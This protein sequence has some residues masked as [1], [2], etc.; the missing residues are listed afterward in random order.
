MKMR[1]T[2]ISGIICFVVGFF[3]GRSD[4]SVETQ[5]R[6]EKQDTIEGSYGVPDLIPVKSILPD[7]TELPTIPVVFWIEDKEH[8]VQKVDTPAIIENYARANY[9]SKILYDD[10][11]GKIDFS[12]KVQYNRLDSLSFKFTP[13]REVRT[14]VKE[15]VFQPFISAGYCTNG[16][17]SFG[18]G[19][20]YHRIGVEYSFQLRVTS[21][22]LQENYHSFKLK[23]LF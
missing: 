19:V 6:Y 12:G 2:L 11:Y 4:K 16:Y 14:E 1:Y 18:G 15:G 10:K 5:V 23:Y 3:I 22:K 17:F 8:I 9:Y 13:I 20:F 21:Y 7:K